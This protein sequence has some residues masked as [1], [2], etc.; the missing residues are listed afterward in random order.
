MLLIWL[1][2]LVAHFVVLVGLAIVAP[3]DLIDITTPPVIDIAFSV[4]DAIDDQS[5]L[6]RRVREAEEE[7]RWKRAAPLVVRVQVAG[8]DDV[9]VEEEEEEVA[10]EA[11]QR[12]VRRLHASAE[13]TNIEQQYLNRWQR[14]VET[15]GNLRFP[16]HTLEEGGG[17]VLTMVEIDALGHMTDMEVRLATGNPLLSAAVRDILTASQPFDAFPQAMADA[18]DRVQVVRVWVFSVEEEDYAP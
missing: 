4:E 9:A 15:I 13:M 17:T 5:I 14:R 12:T 2:V 1:G 11:P 10:P 8:G 6:P 3:A 16:R 18:Y 7:R